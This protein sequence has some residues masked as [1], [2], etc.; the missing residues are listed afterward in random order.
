MINRLWMA[1]P[2][3][4]R[5]GNIVYIILRSWGLLSYKDTYYRNC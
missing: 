2:G 1:Y 5:L 4:G 3:F